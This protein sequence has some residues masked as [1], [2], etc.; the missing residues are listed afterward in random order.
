MWP[1]LLQELLNDFA[2]RKHCGGKLLLCEDMVSSHGFRRMWKF[3]CETDSCESNKLTYR[4]ITPKR[5][6]FFEIDRAA[7]LAFRLIG[8][9][10]SGAKKVASIL[11]IDKPIDLHSWKS[12]TESISLQ[13]E[14]L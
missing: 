9:G 13:C 5:R 12:H 11:N 7:V 8:K 1:L 4:P 10:H 3:E 2:V 14:K 6:H